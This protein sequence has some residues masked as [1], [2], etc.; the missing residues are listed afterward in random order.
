[1]AAQI[2]KTFLTQ[3]LPQLCLTLC[4]RRTLEFCLQ[5]TRTIGPSMSCK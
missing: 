1:M 5:E 2:G 4:A 3:R